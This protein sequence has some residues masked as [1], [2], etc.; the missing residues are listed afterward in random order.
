MTSNIL[1]SNKTITSPSISMFF[2][3]FYSFCSHFNKCEK[4]VKIR[5]TNG[6]MWKVIKLMFYQNDLHRWN[7]LWCCHAGE[8]FDVVLDTK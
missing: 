4:F 3:G 6:F 5:C 2:I 7:S 8:Y 1:E